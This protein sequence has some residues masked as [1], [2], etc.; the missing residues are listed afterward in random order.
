MPPEINQTS[1]EEAKAAMG[2]SNALV[3]QLLARQNPLQ[4]EEMLP[5]EE[6]PAEGISRD[7]FEAFKEEVSSMIEE[8]LGSIREDISNALK[9]DEE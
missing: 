9:S 5:M 2:H 4:Q 3:E 8:K 1:P 6:S 7:E